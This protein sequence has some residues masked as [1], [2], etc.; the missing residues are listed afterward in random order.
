MLCKGQQTCTVSPALPSAR[1]VF[2][3][4]AGLTCSHWTEFSACYSSL[5]GGLL[6]VSM[7]DIRP[8]R[9][10]A[11]QLPGWRA[12]PHVPAG[13]AVEPPAEL[14]WALEFQIFKKLWSSV[15]QQYEYT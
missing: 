15:S 11:L 13:A 9:L 2:T 5:Q 7:C 1:G 3:V 10:G 6:Q 8:P 4:H 14:G 12:S